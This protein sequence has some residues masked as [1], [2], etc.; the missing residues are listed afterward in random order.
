MKNYICPIH[1]IEYYD[2]RWET[3]FNLSNYGNGYLD[4]FV[5]WDDDYIEIERYD[6]NVIFI[7]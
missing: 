7:I 2:T 5:Y 6:V 3:I 4:D 1:E